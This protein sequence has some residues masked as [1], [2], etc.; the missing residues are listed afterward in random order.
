MHSCDERRGVAVEKLS[1]EFAREIQLDRERI[2]REMLHDWALKRSYR[3]VVEEK[4]EKV[5]HEDDERV[6]RESIARRL[7]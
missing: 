6:L 2:Y 7:G 5:R 3:E 4:L 1:I